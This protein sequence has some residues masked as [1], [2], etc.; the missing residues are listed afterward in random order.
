MIKEFENIISDSDLLQAPKVLRTHC[1]CQHPSKY[2]IF[3][4]IC[5]SSNITWSEFEKHIWCYDC[6]KDILLTRYFAGIFDG[7]IP[8]EL[9]HCMGISFDRIC[10]ADNSIVKENIGNEIYNTTWV[11]DEDLEK[12][13]AIVEDK[14]YERKNFV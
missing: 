7:P 3:C 14:L 11:R 8:M 10:L 6:E 5:G 2:D 13:E 4:P 12:Y 1:Y 9:S